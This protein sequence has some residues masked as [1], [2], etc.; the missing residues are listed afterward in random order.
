[1]KL[2]NI[3]RK[4]KKSFSDYRPSV[5]VLI[6]R[7]NLLHNL[8]GYNQKYPQL[9][10]APVLKSNAYGHGLIEVAQIL[11]KKKN[12]FL[13]VDSLFE[14][15]ALR[16]EG[17]KSQILIIGYTSAENING[18][19]IF[20]TAFTITSLDQLQEIN[21][22]LKNVKKFHLKIDTG[23]HRQ[24]ILPDEIEKA[25]KIIQQN[26]HINLE[27]ICSHLA[28]ADNENESF[29]QFQIN[30]WKKT[31]QIFKQNFVTIKFFHLSA[32]AGVKYI[33]QFFSNT[34]RL[35]L[36]LYGINPSPFLKMNL[37]PVLEMQSIVSSVKSVAIG[38]CVGYNATF[39]ADK[40][41]RIAA[42]PV[43]YFEGVDR[44]LSN[45]GYFKI[46]DMQCPIVGR[47]S[48]NI[49]SLDITS[50]SGVKLGDQVWVIS[51]NPQDKNSI[52]NMAKLAE[53]IPYEIL[54]HIPQHLRRIVK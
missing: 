25:I 37:K 50:A 29:T 28:D 21:R 24:G 6:Y 8:N 12:A 40:A 15:K 44:R 13:V 48:M 46:N 5:E 32:T 53:T 14:A 51:I 18:S 1:M 11:D 2:L 45:K 38:E 20:G 39:K 34:V 26:E 7:E 17:I 19:Q 16:S 10:F 36:G 22:K 9:S 54:I 27:G 52:E 47:V 23:M 31:V 49:T 4:I 30:Q 41:I 33:D 35:G 3:L 43:G 42:I